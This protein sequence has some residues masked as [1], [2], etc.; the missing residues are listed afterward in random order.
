MITFIV[1][2]GSRT[3]RVELPPPPVE[4][5]RDASC[6]LVLDDSRCSRRHLRLEAHAEGLVLVDLDAPNRTLL[7]GEPVAQAVLRRG[8][9]VRIGAT[10]LTFLGWDGSSTPRGGGSGLAI[11]GYAPGPRLGGGMLSAVYEARQTALDRPVV[12]KVLHERWAGDAAAAA[13]FRELVK[14]Q[15]RNRH[16]LPAA[17]LASGD[18]EGGPYAVLERVAGTTLEERVRTRMALNPEGAVAVLRPL[19][20]LLAALHADG[21]RLEWLA[22]GRLLLTPEGGL[23]LTGLGVPLHDLE[24]CPDEHL[25]DLAFLAPE[26]VPHPERAGPEADLFLVGALG[27]YLLKGRTGREADAAASAQRAAREDPMVDLAGTPGL[28]RELRGLLKDLCNPDPRKRPRAGEALERLQ[29]QASPP[30]PKDPPVSASTRATGNG[31][32]PPGPP[33][34]SARFKLVSALV[35]VGLFVVVN[36]AFFYF[37]WPPI[38]DLL[39]GGNGSQD[40]R[41]AGAGEGLPHTAAGGGPPGGEETGGAGSGAEGEGARPGR[42]DPTSPPAMPSAQGRW[43]EIQSEVAKLRAGGRYRKG[44]ELLESFRRAYASGPETEAAAELEQQLRVVWRSLVMQHLERMERCLEAED[45]SGAHEARQ[46][47]VAAGAADAAPEHL[48]ALTRR[49]KELVAAGSRDPG[50][51]DEPPGAPESAAGESEAT[52]PLPPEAWPGRLERALADPGELKLR[53]RLLEAVEKAGP[54]GEELAG[55]FRELRAQEAVLAELRSTLEGLDGKPL[56]VILEGRGAVEGRPVSAGDTSLVLE[57][58]QGRLEVSWGQVT[59]GGWLGLLEL[60]E[61]TL[62]RYL[63]QQRLHRTLGRHA[64]AWF[65]L[66]AVRLLAGEDA[67]AREVATDGLEELTAV[68]A[69]KPR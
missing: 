38:R 68:L 43:E 28:S 13:R 46:E 22:P 27:H 52:G 39:R 8:D 48:E 58:A 61:P 15:C 62:E 54:P 26:A 16:P 3:R 44:L 59:P 23:R 4:I 45:A 9:H 51:D 1:E 12:V 20:E 55:A 49:L 33:V 67:A 69:G 66:H 34:R 57:T 63:V 24:A 65:D 11:P 25:Q 10:E 40:T 50:P 18:V 2:Q 7:N 21:D 17:L 56:A 53:G 37:A 36:V 6:A 31:E 35:T 64:D 29:A 5:G 42:Q 47:A 32:A 41:Q 19:L 14:R 30:A 60:C